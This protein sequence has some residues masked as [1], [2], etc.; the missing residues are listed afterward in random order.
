M[1]VTTLDRDVTLFKGLRSLTIDS[2]V[3]EN[4]FRERE[5]IAK[6]GVFCRE[7][8]A[9]RIVTISDGRIEREERR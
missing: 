6:H 8:F 9:D 4:R 1:G 3:I 5:L 7:R 2:D